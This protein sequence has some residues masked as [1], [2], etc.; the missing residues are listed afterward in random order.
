MFVAI[1]LPLVLLLHIGIVVCQGT[2][3]PED[4]DESIRGTAP[5][6]VFDPLTKFGVPF[7]NYM[8]FSNGLSDTVTIGCYRGSNLVGYIGFSNDDELAAYGAHIE[9]VLTD[10]AYT[11]RGSEGNLLYSM[12]YPMSKLD[13]ILSILRNEGPLL[14]YIEGNSASSRF[15]I[16]TG[17]PQLVGSD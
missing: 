12:L 16:V 9:P 13:D 10:R 8:I 15:G 14:F 5:P 11:A 2:F 1:V 17:S 7:D 6:D 4:M 3:E